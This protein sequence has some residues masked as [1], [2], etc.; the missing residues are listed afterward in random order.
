MSTLRVGEALLPSIAYG[1]AMGL[2]V[3]AKSASEIAH[4]YGMIDRLIPPQD[5]P[6]YTENLPAGTTSDDT[7]LSV[8]VAEALIAAD[9]FDI[10]AQAA[11]HLRIYQQTAK[12]KKPNGDWLVRGWGGSTT[13][14]MGRLAA[15]ISP[16]ES[17]QAEGA[18]NGIVMK[19]APLV[20]WQASRG[21]DETTRSVQY[22]QL[23]TMTHDS[24]I[25]RACT[26][27]HGEILHWLLAHPGVTIP[28]F[29]SEVLRVVAKEPRADPK[30]RIERAVRVP[31]STLSQL[32]TR[33][34]N[35]LTNGHYGFFVPN[36]IAM[37]YDVFMASRADYTTTVTNAANL[38]GDADS[39][40]SIAGAMANAWSGGDFERPLDFRATQNHEAL[41]ELSREFAKKALQ[42]V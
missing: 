30:Q 18:G 41:A 8:A 9:G 15:G 5:N 37:A 38:G 16:Y 12:T 40:A 27:L 13:N 32:I 29:Q 39:I 28:E 23:T 10:D 42:L 19:M 34:T 20:Y 31:L 7:Q 6:Y 14:A 21:T 2:P 33:Y 35:G 3:E 26:R 4:R 25:A 11:E 22:D 1:D 36:T 17:G 24:D